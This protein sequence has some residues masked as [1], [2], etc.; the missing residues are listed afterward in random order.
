MGTK[1]LDSSSGRIADAL[2]SQVKQRVLG[3]M[4]SDPARS[5]H[6]Q[7]IIALVNSGTGAV[8]RE[9]AR[10]TE[11]GL[12]QRTRQG[13]QVRF[14]IN[15]QSP[16]YD[17]LRGLILKTLGVVDVLRSALA[18]LAPEVPA[19]FVFGSVASQQ[20]ANGSDIDVFIISDTVAYA[21][22]YAALEPAH[23][24]LGRDINPTV[25]TRDEFARRVRGESSFV[26]R[27]MERPKLWLIGG[28]D[29]IAS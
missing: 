23:R 6:L 18:P 24:Q 17:E 2:F 26:Q 1:S 9:L 28:E 4:F 22:V 10:L 29:D 21:D 25:Y 11:A 3:L 13:N 15:A 8:Q 5:Y 16:V 12:L 14:Q 27:V 19:A 7:Q 20:D